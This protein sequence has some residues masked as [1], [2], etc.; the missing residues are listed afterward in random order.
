LSTTL[1]ADQW[2]H[3]RAVFEEA[4]ALPPA[5]RDEYLARACGADASMRRQVEGLLASHAGGSGFLERPAIDAF[6]ADLASSRLEGRRL[7]PYEVQTRIGAGGMGEVYKAHDTRLGRTV[8]LKVLLPTASSDGSSRERF[9]REARA[10]AALTHPHIC[11]LHDVGAVSIDEHEPR[12][13]PYLVMEYLA[14]E[15]LAERLARGPLAIDE[16]LTYAR[17]IASALELAHRAG[18]VHRDL[19]PRNIMLTATGAKLLD[20]GLA[21][22]S[23]SVLNTH[24]T[25]ESSELTAPGALLGTLHYMAPEQLEGRD[26]DAR[27]DVF[28]FGCVLYEM[29]S[30]HKAFQARSSASLLT[31]IMVSDPPPLRSQRPGVPAAIDAI[32]TRCLRKNPAD[33]WQSAAELHNALTRVSAAA[34]TPRRVRWKAVAAVAIVTT[35]LTAAVWLVWPRTGVAPA[36]APPRATQLAVLPLRLVGEVDPADRHLGVGIADAIITRLATVRQIGLRPTA[37]VLSYADAPAEPARVAEALGVD[38][39]L[40][41]TIQPTAAAYRVTLQLVQGPASSV[42]WARSYDVARGT[43]LTLQDT[44]ADQVVDALRIELSSVDRERFKRRYTENAEAYDLYVRG[45][46]SLVNYTEADMKT[47]IDAFERAIDIDPNY[48]LARAGLSIASAW[49]SIRYAYETDAFKWGARAE[50]EARA[51]LAA[52]PSLAEATLA[53]ASAAGTLHGGFDWPKVIE[54]ATQAL[55]LDPT[56][57]LAHVVRMRA[58]FHLGL[59][60]HMANEA[61]ASR[62]INPLGNVEVAR[63]EVTA[64]LFGGA[65][66]RARDQAQALLART[67]APAV[68]NYLGLAQHYLGETAAARTTLAGIQRGGRPDVRSQAALAGVEAAAGDKT[69]ARARAAAID[70]ASRS[71]L[72]EHH[73][74]R[75]PERHRQGKCQPRHRHRQLRSGD[76]QSDD[77]YAEDACD[78]KPHQRVCGCLRQAPRDERTC[79]LWSECEITGHF[80]RTH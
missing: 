71:D 72:P 48:A 19:K 11:T 20:F 9:E 1:S 22:T 4:L 74:G 68:R 30:G 69:A 16:A 31:A 70:L 40:V 35:V 23:A 10:V 44:I 25:N 21:K 43:L 28:G 75:C 37:A 33:R 78:G 58:F 45:R 79:D 38:H 65:Y 66:G 24:A 3:I 59:F 14:G 18:I 51:A 27:T 52:D 50:Q 26:A 47:A 55:S 5:A 17:Q 13:V 7:G 76:E 12:P 73:R 2:R 64:S 61:L 46:A 63:L 56:L 57:D 8:A 60:D 41:G 49:F 32:V 6:A 15:T 36:S 39:V 80:Q 42:A 34:V 54:A 77:E 62:R 53:L 67:D 29:L